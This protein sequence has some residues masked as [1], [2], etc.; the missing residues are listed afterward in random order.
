MKQNGKQVSASKIQND[1]QRFKS[2]SIYFVDYSNWTSKLSI[3]HIYKI[4]NTTKIKG[5]RKQKLFSNKRN[6]DSDSKTLFT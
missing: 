5:M 3:S 2:T 1:E 4:M 6:I